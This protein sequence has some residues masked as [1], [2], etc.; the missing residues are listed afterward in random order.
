MERAPQIDAAAVVHGGLVDGHDG[1]KLAELAGGALVIPDARSAAENE[2][3]DH[4]SAW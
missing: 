4:A 1:V 3:S 2:R